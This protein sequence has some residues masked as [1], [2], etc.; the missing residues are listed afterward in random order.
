MDKQQSQSTLG[1]QNSQPG[2]DQQGAK[3]HEQRLDGL[4]QQ[5]GR[6]ASGLEQLIAIM[7]DTNLRQHPL[8]PQFIS[9]KYLRLHRRMPRIS[10]VTAG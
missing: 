10:R 4:D 8:P 2:K 9:K 1:M 7:K 3:T 5:V 6:M